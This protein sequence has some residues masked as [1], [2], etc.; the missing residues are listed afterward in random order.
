V[1]IEFCFFVE[2]RDAHRILFLVV[3]RDAYR[4]LFL[5]K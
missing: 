2:M 5:W 1:R 4:I 3:M